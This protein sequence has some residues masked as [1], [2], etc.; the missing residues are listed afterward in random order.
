M[1]KPRFSRRVSCISTE[2]RYHAHRRLG[3]KFFPLVFRKK[4]CKG[5][6][7]RVLVLKA[8]HRHTSSSYCDTLCHVSQ[9]RTWPGIGPR[10]SPAVTRFTEAG[11]GAGCD[12]DRKDRP[13]SAPWRSFTEVDVVTRSGNSKYRL[14]TISFLVNHMVL[15]LQSA[16]CVLRLDYHEA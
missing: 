2:S 8:T 6:H 7:R 14:M 10:R 5:L 15:S 13:Q 9:T 3:S 11:C 12:G 16:S 4:T 1:T